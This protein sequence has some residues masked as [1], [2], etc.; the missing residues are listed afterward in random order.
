MQRA[1][2]DG[3]DVSF[4]S[5]EAFE[6]VIWLSQLR[7]EIVHSN[8]LKPLSPDIISKHFSQFFSMSIKKLLLEKGG[9]ENG[10][11]YLSKN[12]ANCSRIAAISKMFPNSTIIVPFR[13]PLAHVGSLLKIHQQFSAEHAEDSF[14]KKYMAWIGHY[15]IGA[16]FKPID[17]D[18]WLKNRSIASYDETFWLE[19]WTAAYRNI[20]AQESSNICFINFDQL[21]L[22]SKSILTNLA[23]RIKLKNK[24]AL[25]S[26]AD[27]LRSPTSKPVSD[28]NLPEA[29]I[30]SAHRVH[31][32][33]IAR[34][35]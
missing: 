27:M 2:G 19:Y 11:R 30:D 25:V 9:L 24:E 17:F 31:E 6:E 7:N 20:L 12:N 14:S 33:L 22:D 3:M 5:P 10:I 15:D 8:H 35:I 18:H 29:V 21:L 1:H 4:D 28:S 32:Q 26:Q 13:E 23:D 34:Q 16:N